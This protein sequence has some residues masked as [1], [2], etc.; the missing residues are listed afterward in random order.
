MNLSELLSGPLGQSVINNVSSQLGM[1]KAEASSAVGVAVPAILAG[2]TK[3]SQSAQG[4]ESLNKALESKHD[5]S[6]LDNLSSMFQNQPSAVQQDG[7]GIL[8]HIFGK[9]KLAVEK[10]VAQK[11]GLSLEKVRPLLAMLAPIV[12]A[13][14]GKQKRQTNTAS[15][16]LGDLLGGLLGGGGASAKKTSG[17]GLLDAVA[18]MLGGGQKKGGSIVDD[19]LGGLLK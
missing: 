17:G 2:L 19:I 1:N 3:N 14:V 12:M 10:G 9:N 5:G 18:G 8:E 7:N 15:G 11:S 16:G 13:Y 6:L 4:A